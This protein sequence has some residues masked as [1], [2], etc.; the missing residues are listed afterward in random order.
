MKNR[1][2]IK[3]LA[4]NAIFLMIFSCEKK[5]EINKPKGLKPIDWENYN[6]VYTVGFN[7]AKYCSEISFME[8]FDTDSL[9]KIKITGWI[10]QGP[11]NPPEPINPAHFLLTN[12][13]ENIFGWNSSTKGE[14]GCYIRVSYLGDY[15]SLIDSLRLKF[16]ATDVTM[17]CYVSGRLMYHEIHSGHCCY[18]YPVIILYS[19][20]D[21]YFE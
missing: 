1:I 2:I 5:C 10:F 3:L 20:N 8:R 6:D 21:I 17:K 14:T 4:I 7:C 18:A 19:A 16:E 15:K 12:N 13:K 9:K 11:G